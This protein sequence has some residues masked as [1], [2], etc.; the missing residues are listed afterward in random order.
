[1]HHRRVPTTHR[2]AVRR[3]VT[4]P[5]S[6]KCHDREVERQDVLVPWLLYVPSRKVVVAH[7]VVAQDIP[8]RI[9]RKGGMDEEVSRPAA[10]LSIHV[11]CTTWYHV[12]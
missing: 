11:R 5:H 8:V 7:L 12:R 4:I 2:H 10:V 6:S 1:M 3:Y 9:E